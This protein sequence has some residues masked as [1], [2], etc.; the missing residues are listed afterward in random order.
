MAQ[1]TT[2]CPIRI[3]QAISR[4]GAFAVTEDGSTVYIPVTVWQVARP[5]PGDSYEAKLIAGDPE[6]YPGTKDFVA[7]HIGGRLA[8][9]G[10]IDIG[11]RIWVWDDGEA[12]AF[13]D[14]PPAPGVHAY[15][16]TRVAR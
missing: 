7:V 8:T 2:S 4:G 5:L 9:G 1:P 15:E 13:D 16:Y 11:N 3:T 14:A 10:S 12:L 6:I